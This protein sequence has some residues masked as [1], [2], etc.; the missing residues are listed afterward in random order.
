MSRFL[1]LFADARLGYRARYYSAVPFM[2]PLAPERI[3]RQ[4]CP[5][6]NH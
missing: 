1:S 4:H 3:V 2:R 6:H 5:T